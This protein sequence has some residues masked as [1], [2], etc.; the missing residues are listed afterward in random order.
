MVEM[1]TFAE[2]RVVEKLLV[3][4]TPIPLTKRKTGPVSG[5]AKMRS[6]TSFLASMNVFV[7]FDR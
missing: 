1:V 5:G 2:V 7:F 6:K 4:R 3:C